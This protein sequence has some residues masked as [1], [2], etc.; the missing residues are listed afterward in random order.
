MNI[1]WHT[2]MLLAIASLAISGCSGEDDV[3]RVNK[4]IR[5]TA[6]YAQPA[7]Q[8]YQQ[9]MNSIDSARA[10]KPLYLV[11][12]ELNQYAKTIDQAVIQLAY[13]VTEYCPTVEDQ[14]A[15]EN[16]D[17]GVRTIYRVNKVRYK[18]LSE[19][20]AA[21]NQASTAQ[22]L[23]VLEKYGEVLTELPTN[24]LMAMAHLVSAK[25]SVGLSP[26]LHEFN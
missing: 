24:A 8:A 7:D 21:L 1:R 10:G 22:M 23:V 25:Q 14:Q 18:F 2:L 20:A 17:I 19:I 11:A 26:D 3:T 15:Q 13:L 5:L 12:E 6:V 16:L 9:A 4:V